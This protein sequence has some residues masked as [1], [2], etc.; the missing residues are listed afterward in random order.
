MLY[1][2][3]FSW[4]RLYTRYHDFSDGTGSTCRHPPLD[5]PYFHSVMH[6]FLYYDYR[7]IQ[8]YIC[9]SICIAVYFDN[10]K[11]NKCNLKQRF[12]AI[13][14]FLIIAVAYNQKILVIAL[15]LSLPY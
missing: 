15:T 1:L 7:S 14:I 8:Q 5:L 11:I 12:L 4:M 9:N 2:L 3:Y 6:T 10:R 13:L